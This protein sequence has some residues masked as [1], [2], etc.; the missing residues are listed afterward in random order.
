[1]LAGDP[2]E[3]LTLQRSIE[4]ADKKRIEELAASEKDA[5]LESLKKKLR[6]GMRS[7][8]ATHAFPMGGVRL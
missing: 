7:P 2:S 6:V 4:A 5:E 8:Q 1:M 3:L